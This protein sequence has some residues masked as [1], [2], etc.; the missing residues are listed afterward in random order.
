MEFNYERSQCDHVGESD[1][2]G[3]KI[4]NHAD[5]NTWRETKRMLITPEQFRQI[6]QILIDG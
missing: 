5:D 2:Y 3:I 6:T 1:Y 4:D